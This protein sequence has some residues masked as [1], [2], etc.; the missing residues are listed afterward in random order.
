[1]CYYQGETGR[2]I[3]TL[4][5]VYRYYGFTAVRKYAESF[6]NDLVIF[7]LQLRPRD[8]QMDNIPERLELIKLGAMLGRLKMAM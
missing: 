1:M 4:S 6:T 3:S 8:G 7:S 2:F 5:F